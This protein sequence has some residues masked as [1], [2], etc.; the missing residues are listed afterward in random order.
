MNNPFSGDAKDDDDD[1]DLLSDGGGDVGDLMQADLEISPLVTSVPPMPGDAGGPSLPRSIKGVT[2]RLAPKRQKLATD[3][4]FLERSSS[5]FVAAPRPATAVAAADSATSQ[6]AGTGADSSAVG[7][8]EGSTAGSKRPAEDDVEVNGSSANEVFVVDKDEESKRPALPSQPA[9][10][11]PRAV[12]T[13]ASPEAKGLES[14]V[15]KAPPVAVNQESSDTTKT[16]N[17]APPSP[18]SLDNVKKEQRM[19]LMAI[20]MGTKSPKK[21]PPPKA[22]PPTPIQPKPDSGPKTDTPAPPVVASVAATTTTTT[23]ADAKPAATTSSSKAA[24][25]KARK[26]APKPTRRVLIGRKERDMATKLLKGKVDL[27]DCLPKEDCEFLGKEMW[28]FTAQQL[29]SV[30]GK[31]SE[32]EK[33]KDGEKTKKILELRTELVEELGRHMQRE[34]GVQVPKEVRVP[35]GSGDNTPG[36]SDEQRTEITQNEGNS[37]ETPVKA[38][39][40]GANEIEKARNPFNIPNKQGYVPIA[41]KPVTEPLLVPKQEPE[42]MQSDSE[43]QPL[44]R[45]YRESDDD[46]A[47]DVVLEE[48]RERAEAK[49]KDW[50]ELLKKALKRTDLSDLKKTF[51]LDGPISILIPKSTQNFVASIKVTTIFDFLSL[52]RT[53]TGAVCDMMRCWREHCGLTYQN[54]LALAKHLLGVSFRIESSISSDVPLDKKSRRWM[55]DPIIVLTG[56]AREF[57]VDYLRILTANRFLTTRTKDLSTALATWREEK[58]LVPLKG[59]GKVAMVSGWKASAREERVLVT[60][61]GKIVTDVDLEAQSA[62]DIPIVRDETKTDTKIDSPAA[63]TTSS[64][65]KP[66]AKK[67]KPP[68]PKIQHG[69]ASHSPLFLEHVLGN[70]VSSFLS[71]VNISTA[72]DLEN[73]DTSD[74]SIFC[75]RLIENKR[76][77]DHSSCLELVKKWQSQLH[78]Q[79]KD[80]PKDE[81]PKKVSSPAPVRTPKAAPV[82]T[83]KAAPVSERGKH[84]TPR[85]LTFSDPFDVLSAVTKVFLA[86]MDI[87]T[88]KEFLSTRTTDISNEFVRWREEQGKPELKGLGAIASVSGWKAACRK[89]ATDMGLH[90]IAA[91]EPDSK[92]I[93]QTSKGATRSKPRS[94]A[95]KPPPASTMTPNLPLHDE[96]LLSSGD[97]LAGKSRIEFAVQNPQGKSGV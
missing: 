55:K 49:L 13:G 97:D 51:P 72:L 85:Y 52:R 26:K 69:Y 44:D 23:T 96:S 38:S 87:N 68:Q 5:S 71:T 37:A 56:A 74:D 82:R 94:T 47:P 36:T 9:K 29:L 95:T 39:A 45:N 15:A 35:N 73:V 89:A 92:P 32:E 14:N 57:L 1:G 65:S 63:G 34:A 22:Q 64:A 11:P 84:R 53:E 20:V 78:A 76:A 67:P 59:S 86:T 24:P 66:L 8:R 40:E 77:N 70:D 18:S 90:D 60:E 62:K 4:Q 42:K 93:P 88:G 54:H 28:I 10:D 50:Q 17:A 81:K 2:H 58:G 46:T 19:N 6:L 75:Q 91:L 83:P 79:L 33:A 41:P 30:L 12:V 27:L 80:M 21:S 16:T 7:L 25:K 61:A 48:Y 3:S 43:V 31:L